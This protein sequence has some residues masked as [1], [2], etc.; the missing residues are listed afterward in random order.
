MLQH[1]D[2]F[3]S[4][5]EWYNLSYRVSSFKKYLNPLLTDLLAWLSQAYPGYSLFLINSKSIYFGTSAAFRLDQQI[6]ELGLDREGIKTGE[7]GLIWK[8]EYDMELKYRQTSFCCTVPYFNSEH[9]CFSQIG[10]MWQSCIKQIYQNCF[11]SSI[12]SLRVSILH[13]SNSH[14]FSNF[15]IFVIFIIIFV[16]VICNQGLWPAES[17]NNS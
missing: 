4:I 8:N 12:C 16:L 6:R 2:L 5:T 14:N 17:S 3:H 11:S 1:F 13:F 9:M 10:G 7:N 15:L